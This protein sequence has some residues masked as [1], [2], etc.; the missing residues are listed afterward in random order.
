MTA[1]GLAQSRANE[2][3]RK[4]IAEF[5]P[6]ASDVSS[7]KRSSPM[8]AAAGA[9]NGPGNVYISDTHISGC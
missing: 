4:A 7:A 6:G 8:Q 2:E 5:F 1:D 9:V 3:C